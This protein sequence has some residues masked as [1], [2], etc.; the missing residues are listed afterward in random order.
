MKCLTG[1]S[2]VQAFPTLIVPFLI[3]VFND[4]SLFELGPQTLLLL[5]S[6]LL[7]GRFDSLN[8]DSCLAVNSCHN[9]LTLKKSNF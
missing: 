9:G 7:Q 3:N 6:L 1:F 2:P 5:W 8:L 4:Y